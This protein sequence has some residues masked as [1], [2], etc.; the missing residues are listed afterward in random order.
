MSV[1]LSA[2]MHSQN[3]STDRF[4]ELIKSMCKKEEKTEPE[5]VIYDYL[6]WSFLLFRSYE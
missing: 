6:H 3:H 2:Y 4:D 5:K 1:K